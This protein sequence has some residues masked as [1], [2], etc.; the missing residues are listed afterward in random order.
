[1]I[2]KTE[3]WKSMVERRRMR[4]TFWAVRGL[5]LA[6]FIGLFMGGKPGEAE[7]VD[8]LP[9]HQGSVTLAV[10]PDTEGYTRR[11]P[12]YF[13]AQT[14]WIAENAKQRNI[15]YTIHLGDITNRNTVPEWIVARRC[16]DLLK[17]KVPYAVVP[18]NHDYDDSGYEAGTGRLGTRINDYFQFDAFRKSPHYGGVFEEGRMENTYHL[19]KIHDQDWLILC[20]ELGPRDE[21]VDWANKVLVQHADRQAII[22]THAYLYYGNTRYDRTKGSQRASPAGWGNEGEEL[23]RKLIRRHPNTQIV[24]CGHLASMY[25]GYRKDEAAYGNDVHQ[26]LCDYEKMRGGGMGYLRL[27]EFLPDGKTVQ[28][29]TYSPVLKQ[30]L[31]SKLEEFQF[32]LK[33]ADRKTPIPLQQPL[34]PPWRKPIHRYSFNGQA[35]EQPAVSQPAAGQRIVDSI[36]QAHGQLISQ[37]GKSRCQ[38]GKLTLASN[39]ERDGFVQLPSA[40]LDELTDVGVEVWVTPTAEAYNWNT[41]WKFGDQRSA[42]RGDFFWYAFRTLTTH[43]AESAKDGHN[44][45]IQSKGVPVKPGKPMHIVVTYDH[46]GATEGEQAGSADSPGSTRGPLLRVFRNGKLEGQL[47][48]TISLSDVTNTVNRIG[49]FAGVY[50]ELRIYD[51]PLGPTAVEASFRAGPETFPND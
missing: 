46:D 27:L 9:F 11:R 38:N 37:S 17:G 35:A 7:E 41:V 14:K 34:D 23:W 18:G 20:L 25:K 29:R 3:T 47:K 2:L 15:A 36:G 12:H 16:F 10:L 22:V 33:S 21:V 50:D 4:L 28:V 5:G 43:R 40:M 24:M 45:D 31:T 48:T 8:P 49:P 42:K 51:V 13:E 26:M 6:L 19:L 32:Q 39:E 30:T 1:M 44:L